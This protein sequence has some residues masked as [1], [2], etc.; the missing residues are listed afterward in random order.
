M[1][2]RNTS[3]LLF[4]PWIYDFSAYDFWCKP[5]GLLYVGAR[6]RQLGCHVQLIDCLDRFHPKLQPLLPDGVKSKPDMSGK[7]YRE[8]IE[9]QPILRYVFRF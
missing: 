8:I 1:M 3:V 6:L 2:F 4:N 5:L 9:K 7:F